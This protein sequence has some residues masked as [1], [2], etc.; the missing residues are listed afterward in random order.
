M[1][2][3][4]FRWT[5]GTVCPPN[6]PKKGDSL[7][8]HSTFIYLVFKVFTQSYCLLFPVL[9]D[10]SSGDYL[11][12]WPEKGCSL[13]ACNVQAELPQGA[14]ISALLKGTSCGYL[15]SEKR[16]LLLKIPAWVPDR[17]LNTSEHHLFSSI[18]TLMH[19]E[20]QLGTNAVETVNRV[21]SPQKGQDT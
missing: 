14:F 20:K 15:S 12:G 16:F 18:K 13:Y 1:C 6:F 5:E 2:H 8:A 19:W 7:V 11:D 21:V 10:E 9:E 3:C 17:S 4:S